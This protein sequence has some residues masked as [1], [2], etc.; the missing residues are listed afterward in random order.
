MMM[1]A[2]EPVKTYTG[3][4]QHHLVIH[5]NE[6]LDIAQTDCAKPNRKT[7]KQT[8]RTMVSPDA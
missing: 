7:T 8:K 5:Q 1:M 4:F 3:V 2:V 6:E